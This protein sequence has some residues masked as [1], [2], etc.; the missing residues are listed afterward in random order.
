M[1]LGSRNDRSLYEMSLSFPPRLYRDAIFVPHRDSFSWAQNAYLVLGQAQNLH[2][3]L[4]DDLL[5][6]SVV[7]VEQVSARAF[8]AGGGSFGSRLEMLSLTSLEILSSAPTQAGWLTLLLPTQLDFIFFFP[9]F[10]L[11]DRSLCFSTHLGRQ[12]N[13]LIVRRMNK[14]KNRGKFQHLRCAGGFIES[15]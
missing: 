7:D 3:F 9:S 14:H 4:V 15:K 10:T 12:F 2:C 13:T 1:S 8:I 5:S 6:N 11:W